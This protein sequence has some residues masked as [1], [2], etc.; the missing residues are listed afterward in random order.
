M[1]H[2]TDTRSY[3][4]VY[5]LQIYDTQK[6]KSCPIVLCT[7]I[8]LLLNLGVDFFNLLPPLVHYIKYPSR[9]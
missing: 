1:C 5:P 6:Y 2:L 7:R 9:L 3:Y 4:R 8:T